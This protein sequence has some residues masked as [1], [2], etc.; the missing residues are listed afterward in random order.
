MA[1]ECQRDS[2]FRQTSAGSF[3]DVGRKLCEAS[4]PQREIGN[5]FE[6]GAQLQM[7]PFVCRLEFGDRPITDQLAVTA[8]RN[9]VIPVRIHHALSPPRL[10]GLSGRALVIAHICLS[11]ERAD[12]LVP[13][14]PLKGQQLIDFDAGARLAPGCSSSSVGARRV[15]LSVVD[16]AVTTSRW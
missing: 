13:R 16:A 11:D 12:R 14:S 2:D 15:R 8:F 3:P 10:P 1:I 5:R 7:E 4:I 6:R 9:D